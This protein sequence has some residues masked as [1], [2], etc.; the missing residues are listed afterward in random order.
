MTT[1]RIA[2]TSSPTP[3]HPVGR[4][5][6]LALSGIVSAAITAVGGLAG[7][8]WAIGVAVVVLLAANL[9]ALLAERGRW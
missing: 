5:Q 4:A 3:R 6:F 7:A 1:R 2:V 8:P 9:A